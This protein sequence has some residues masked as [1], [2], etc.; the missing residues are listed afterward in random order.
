MGLSYE[1]FQ[2]KPRDCKYDIARTQQLRG[3]A[4]RLKKG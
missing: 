3:E 1:E 4:K 2:K